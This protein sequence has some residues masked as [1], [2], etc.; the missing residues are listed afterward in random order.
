[1]KTKRLILRNGLLTLLLI[2]SLS[3]DGF[4]SVNVSGTVASS[5]EI[6]RHK[7]KDLTASKENVFI[8]TLK[9]W[10]EDG[11]YWMSNSVKES[12]NSE[13][14]QAILQTTVS[15]KSLTSPKEDSELFNSLRI[16]MQN[17]FYWDK[18]DE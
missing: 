9:D 16:W 11:L 18:M 8:E 2:L 1:M 14:P 7:T 15:D 4:S 3:L 6:K 17:G 5:L 10:M 12:E 13:I